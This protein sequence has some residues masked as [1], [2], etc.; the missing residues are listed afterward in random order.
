M[1]H[2]NLSLI[3]AS[4]DFTMKKVQ[5]LDARADTSQLTGDED[6]PIPVSRNESFFMFK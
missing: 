2:K 1:S 4:T 5:E 6:P 3:P